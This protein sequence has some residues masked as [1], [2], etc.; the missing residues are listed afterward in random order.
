MGPRGPDRQSRWT[1]SR[2]KDTVLARGAGSA[3]VLVLF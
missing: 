3:L 1:R 2:R